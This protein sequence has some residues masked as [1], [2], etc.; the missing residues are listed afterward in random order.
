[1][2]N[3]AIFKAKRNREKRVVVSALQRSPVNEKGHRSE[4]DINQCD[5]VWKVQQIVDRE[6]HQQGASRGPKTETPEE[7]RFH[8]RFW[9]GGGIPGQVSEF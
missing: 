7:K 1:L 2:G 8:E 3:Q 9:S 4:T 5:T 6:D